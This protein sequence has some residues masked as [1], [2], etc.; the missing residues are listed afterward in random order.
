VNPEALDRGYINWFEHVRAES[1]YV[2]SIGA[3]PRDGR[4]WRSGVVYLLPPGTFSA[5]PASRELVSP[6]A[7]RPRARLHVEPDDFP[8][9]TQTLA[10]RPGD[11]PNRVVLRHALRRLS[12]RSHARRRSRRRAQ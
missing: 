5:T 1:R 4:S 9:R 11:T 12:P 6:V 7:V 3:D 2:F 8:F 10:H